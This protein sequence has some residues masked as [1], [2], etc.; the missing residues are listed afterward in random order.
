MTLKMRKKLTSAARC[1]IKMRSEE[2]DRQKGIKL[3]E[4]DL[5]N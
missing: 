2:S 3:L 5:K 4:R 1:A